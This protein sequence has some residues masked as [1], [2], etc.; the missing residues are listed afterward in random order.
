VRPE[1][2]DREGLMSRAWI[3]IERGMLTDVKLL[4]KPG[5]YALL[6]LLL[7]CQADEGVMQGLSGEDFVTLLRMPVTT[8]EVEQALAYFEKRGMIRR[9]KREGDA[10]ATIVVVNYFKY[11]PKDVT[12]A[13]R[14]ARWRERH[15]TERNGA[16]TARH[17]QTDVQTDRQEAGQ[18]GKPSA[19]RHFSE[20]EFCRYIHATWPDIGSNRAPTLH[21]AWK[22]SC[23][24]VDLLREATKAS[25]FE[26]A[27]P[28][29]R[30]HNHAR[31]LDNWFKRQQDRGP[32]ARF[33]GFTEMAADWEA[34]Q[35]AAAS[36]KA[37]AAAAATREMLDEK[38]A[39]PKTSPAERAEILQK[40]KGLA[41]KM[42]SAE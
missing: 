12:G 35:R 1:A 32:G 34:D 28:T 10:S 17:I 41:G 23:P 5:W 2:T 37:K 38:T 26:V 7:L 4:G 27:N 39:V 3:R 29:R 6:W 14:S 22:A 20:C 21:Q 33:G 16:A 19:G 25:A 31:F 42:G 40:V 11:Q 18:P 13:E 24:G 8:E 36:K 30:K 9:G 15:G